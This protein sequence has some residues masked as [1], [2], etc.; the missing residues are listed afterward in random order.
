M[1]MRK[2]LLG[3]RPFITCVVAAAGSSER[4]NGENKLFAPLCGK[5]VLAY[6]LE[7]FEA[8]PEISEIIVVT[9]PGCL[10][11]VAALCAQYAPEKTS[12][13]IPGGVTRLDSALAGALA[14]S[15]KARFIAVHDGARPLVTQRVISDAVSLALKKNAAVPAVPVTDTI[16]RAADGRIAET[17]PRDELFVAQTPQVF[18]A[19]LLKAALTAAEEKKLP[20][21]DDSSAVE[22]LGMSVF[23]SEGDPDNIKITLPGDIARAEGILEGR[24]GI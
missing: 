22:A 6:S 21:T 23:L 14:A 12:A 4:M 8:A 20:V 11:D 13:V 18:D 9:R 2:R 10:A 5:P 19:E 1:S 17:P 3:R 16:K 7:A 15:G 24:R